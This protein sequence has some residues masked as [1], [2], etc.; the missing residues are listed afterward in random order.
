MKSNR[1]LAISTK[2]QEQKRDN[3]IG[4]L[5]NEFP[6]EILSNP[7][8]SAKRERIFTP[9]TTLLTMVLTSSQ[10]DKTLKNSVDLYYGIH[11]R[12]RKEIL[13]G[14][15]EE[16]QKEEE[17]QKNRGKRKVGRPKNNVLQIQKSK[18]NDISL[19]TAAYS[20]ARARLP[21][22]L[23][24]ELFNKSLIENPSNTYSH[25]HGHRVFIADGTYVQM[26]DTPELRK[27]YNVFHEGKQ[28]PGYPQGLIEAIV[29]RAT[30]QVYSF[31]LSNRHISELSLFYDLID[32]LPSGCIL[33]VDDLYNCYEIMAKCLKKNIEIVVPAKR[34]RNYETKKI[35]S[36]GDEIIEIKVP[37][38]R[39]KWLKQ[40]ENI[41]DTIELRKITC[42][43]PDGNDYILHT[44]VVEEEISK[45][46]IQT[47]FLTRWDIEISIREIK[48]IMDIN[49]F[50]SKTPEM[51]LKELTVALATYNLIRKMIYASIKDLL[52]FPEEDFIYKFYTLN[53]DIFIDKKRRVYKR[54]STGRKRIGRINKEGNLTKE[55]TRT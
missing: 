3:I 29:E 40:Q 22:E 10:K 13:L 1:S 54:W 20:K 14:L 17:E 36:N 9:A 2:I 15:Q 32:T 43:S 16:N 45:D 49:I 42:Q 11:Q 34:E 52:F 30:G 4:V 21:I 39:S 50:R 31:S 24:I 5:E 6:E 53:T 41:P 23:T 28:S 12:N 33:L 51:V 38:T 26:Q 27:E 44:T 25:W 46:E 19:N 55:R 8:Y 35:I 47:L 18:D 7:A 37:K 48:T